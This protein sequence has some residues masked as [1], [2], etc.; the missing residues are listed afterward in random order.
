MIR[1][2]LRYCTPLPIAVVHEA[3]ERLADVHDALVYDIDL[4]LVVRPS[5]LLSP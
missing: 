3:V 2:A 4:L 1:E 5:L